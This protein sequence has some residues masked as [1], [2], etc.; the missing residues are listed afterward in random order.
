[1]RGSYS[2]PFHTWY[3]L[4]MAR[5]SEPAT[6][7]GFVVVDDG[8]KG[9]APVIRGTRITVFSVLGR[10]E[11][12]ETVDDILADNPDLAREAVEAAITYARR[13]PAK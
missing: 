13:Y 11:H 1:L 3:M 8:V 4:L 7:D 12:G 5:T 2:R 10:I 6:R 9:G